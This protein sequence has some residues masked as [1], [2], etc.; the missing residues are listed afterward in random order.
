M[1]LYTIQS[2]YIGAACFTLFLLL[3][4]LSHK[5]REAKPYLLPLL[6]SGLLWTFIEALLYMRFSG[7][8]KLL[9]TKV[10]YLFIASSPVLYALFCLRYLGYQPFLKARYVAILFAIPA[11]TLVLA[12]LYPMV[13]LIWVNVETIDRAGVPFLLLD[14]GPMFYIYTIYCHGL[15]FMTALL[16]F[17]RAWRMGGI[18]RIQSLLVGISAVLP[19]MGNLLYVVKILPESTLDTT[20]LAFAFSNIILTLGF[21]FLHLRDLEP[22]AR[23]LI[24]QGMTDGLIVVNT[25]GQAVYVNRKMKALLDMEQGDYLKTLFQEFPQLDKKGDFAGLTIEDSRYKLSYDVSK[26]GIKDRHS[27]LIGFIYLFRDITERKNL[28]NELRSLAQT[29]PLTGLLNRRYFLERCRTEMERSRRYGGSL[30]LIMV[31]LDHFKAVNDNH[32]HLAGDRVLESFGELCREMLRSSDLMGRFGGEEFALLLIGTSEEQAYQ[33]A[34]R[35]QKRLRDREIPF[36]DKYLRI[37]MSAG[38]T[39]CCPK[40]DR[41]EDLI[42]RADDLLYKAKAEGRD[43]VLYSGNSRTAPLSAEEA[44]KA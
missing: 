30:A 18:L 5:S 19:L 43:R 22:I 25:Q 20:P 34:L 41:L 12:W 1:N 11:L 36:Q 40:E 15:I 38:V 28:E 21:L 39:L 13:P 26:A 16:C 33:L 35:I 9:L 32:G 6:V 3:L 8:A 27:H 31:D 44:S 17:Y 14:H 23:D 24:F 2:L 42:S 10:Q 7:S 29:D 4:V 37:T